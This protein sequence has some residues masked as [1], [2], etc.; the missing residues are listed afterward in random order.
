MGVNDGNAVGSEAG[1]E[2]GTNDGTALGISVGRA[3]GVDDR[4]GVE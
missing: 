1:Y 3:E 2:D 4:D